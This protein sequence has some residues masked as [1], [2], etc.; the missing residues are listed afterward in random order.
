M[1]SFFGSRPK[2]TYSPL[3]SYAD[4]HEKP[5]LT[6]NGRD[7]SPPWFSPVEIQIPG[8]RH[9]RI[10]LILPIAPAFLYPPPSLRPRRKRSRFSLALILIVAIWTIY[11]FAK[12]FG[13][14]D[15]SWPQPPFLG[16][17][18]T[19]VYERADLRRIWQWEITS[20]HYPSYRQSMYISSD[21]QW[22][23]KTKTSG[24]CLSSASTASVLGH[25]AQP[26]YI[27]PTQRSKRGSPWCY[28]GDWCITNL[29][30]Q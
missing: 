14:K 24:A 19:L 16:D 11:A 20:G 10:R 8:Y 9:R 3:P 4:L 17:P 2:Q 30:P 29:L 22:A 18:P 23:A 5:K 25:A 12:R 21:S 13:T 26:W 27:P 1:A 15:K 6:S 7:R 28:L